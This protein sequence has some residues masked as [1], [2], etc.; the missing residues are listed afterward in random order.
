[1]M[2]HPI[3]RLRSTTDTPRAGKVLAMFAILLPVILGILGLVIDGS[4]L[5]TQYRRAQ[6]A[7][8]AAAS[9]AAAALADGQNT[10]AA[11]TAAV[12]YVQTYNELSTATV[13]VNIPPTSGAYAGQTGY[14]EAQVSL[15]VKTYIL[16]AVGMA[17][18]NVIR[19]TSVAGHQAATTGAAVVV[20]DPNPPGIDL[21]TIAGISLPATP[22]LSLGG[23]E[24]LGLGKLRVNGAVHVNTTWGGVDENGDPAGED[25][26]FRDALTC[27]PLLSLTRLD[28]LDIRVTGGVDNEKYY[29]NYQSGQ[30][31]PLRANRKPVPDPYAALPV[32]TTSV[33]PNHVS[34]AVKGGVA[35]I[36]LPLI[37][38]PTTLSPGVY[39]WIQITGGNV[40]FQ[41]GV[42]IIR[43]RHPLTGISLQIVG[44]QVR[45]D[46]VM[47]YI[48]DSPNYS[49]STGAPDATADT[50][51][52]PPL[53]LT[54]AT[55]SVVMNAGLL[56]SRLSPLSGTGSVYDGVLLF[57]NR[58]DRRIIAI[59]REVLL[60]PGPFS[61]TVYAK[62][63]HVIFAA[64]GTLDAKFVVGSMRFAN[65]LDVTLQ[66]SQLLPPARDVFLVQ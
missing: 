7:A 28:A 40:T 22:S 32:P 17:A 9:A 62:W 23:M 1:M 11:Q 4:M 61:G 44:G 64:T 2:V 54:D 13:L 63:G 37:G 51:L 56:G 35:V 42:Y 47:F 21:P 53:A 45:A 18:T 30:K 60:A 20:L 33:D 55:P 24:V 65:V 31:S 57:Q 43:S 14:V 25:C 16:P 8:D 15:P 48:T 58:A 66:S 10:A 34:G 19:S 12:S 27:M 5:R 50:N 26:G 59:V 38:L 29:G 46:G 49:P 36:G 52:S 41:S 3:L 6:H 39:E